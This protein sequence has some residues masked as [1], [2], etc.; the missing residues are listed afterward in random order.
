MTE[1]KLPAVEP[2][3]VSDQALPRVE[4]QGVQDDVV[5]SEYPKWFQHRGTGAILVQSAEE[6]AMRQA[7]SDALPPPADPT[8]DDLAKAE[9]EK[10][11]G[12]PLTDIECMVGPAALLHFTRDKGTLLVFH[13]DQL[14][15][16]ISRMEDDGGAIAAQPTEF[17]TA[18]DPF[19]LRP[20]VLAPP[21]E[22]PAE[23]SVYPAQP[24]SAE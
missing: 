24:E 2:G 18:A 9:L 14:A 22:A 3:H 12:R 16:S 8:E 19:D 5:H 4:G 10:E 21:N 20:I 17:T 13:P 6:E 11:L 23:S 15:A 7:E 1:Q